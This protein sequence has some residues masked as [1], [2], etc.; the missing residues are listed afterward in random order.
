[1]DN[2]NFL[3]ENGYLILDNIFSVNKCEELVK[4]AYKL[5][6]RED[7]RPI[8]N[9]HN[10]SKEVM[11]FMSNKLLLDVIHN[12]FNAQALGLQTEYFFMPPGTKGFSP[13]QD[14]TYVKASSDSFISAWIALT[15]VNNKNGGLI[16][17]PKSHKENQLEQV[18]NESLPSKNQDPN[19]RKMT[20]VIPKKYNSF[21]PEISKGSVMLIHSWLVHASNN[22]NS[23]NN[24]NALLCTYIKEGADF[25]SGS[26]AKR[27]AFKLYEGSK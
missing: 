25:R 19:A 27:E 21:S 4:L 15:N 6:E 16:I 2:I 8:M 5:N 14:N 26:Y 11:E 24:R 22:N 23:K 1:M 12:F 13:H 18:E 17:W 7:F 9:I 10:I 20:S 3:N